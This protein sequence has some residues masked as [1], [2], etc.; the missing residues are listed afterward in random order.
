[1]SNTLR[2]S[3]IVLIRQRLSAAESLATIDANIS[4]APSVKESD[5][6]RLRESVVRWNKEAMVWAWVL[7]ELSPAGTVEA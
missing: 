7:K 2:E 5:R 4:K 3:A 6:A 1:M